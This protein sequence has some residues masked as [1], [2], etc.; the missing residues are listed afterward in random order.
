MTPRSSLLEQLDLPD[1]TR[2]RSRSVRVYLT[3]APGRLTLA[4][5]VAHV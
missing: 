5:K 3:S 1:R 2:L 4:S